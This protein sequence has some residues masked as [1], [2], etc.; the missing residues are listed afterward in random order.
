MSKY[1]S[2]IFFH[3]S[4]QIFAHARPTDSDAM[5]KL[6]WKRQK[7]R[8]AETAETDPFSFSFFFHLQ[9]DQNNLQRAALL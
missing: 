8:H 4:V 3:A 6:F 9:P 5:L 2:V 7:T 1:V